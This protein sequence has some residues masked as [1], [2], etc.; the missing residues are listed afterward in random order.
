LASSVPEASDVESSPSPPR[1]PN[2][3]STTTPT[4]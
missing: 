3:P 2:N 1:P 4:Q